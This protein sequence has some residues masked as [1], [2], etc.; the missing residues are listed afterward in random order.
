MANIATYLARIKNAILG[1]EVRDSIH[2]SIAAIN[3]D[4]GTANTN[5]SNA[6]STA[7]SASTAASQAVSTA[8]AASE[9]SSQAV[10][11]ANAAKAESSTASS[12]AQTALDNSQAAKDAAAAANT[13]AGKANEATTAANAAAANANTKATA[14]ET[15]TSA[16]NTAA[17]TANKAA[18]NLTTIISEA[19]SATEAA[20]AAAETAESKATE[21]TTAATQATAAA[22]KAT[23][24]TTAATQATEAATKATGEANTATE[25]ANEAADAA[26]EAAANAKPTI[27][28]SFSDF[29]RP[30][31]A[32][33][34]YVDSSSD[35]RL[36]YTWDEETSEYVLTG[37]AGGDLPSDAV[38]VNVPAE[39]WALE[40]TSQRYQKTV[41]VEGML[42]GTGG[43]WDIVRAGGVI[44]KEES[45]LSLNITDVERLNNS[46]KIS[47][48]SQPSKQFQ[49][50]LY[51]TYKEAAEGDVLISDMPEWFERVGTNESSIT[52]LG[53]RISEAESG[54][55]QLNTSLDEN[56]FK[57]Y[58]GLI[59]N[60]GNSVAR[61]YAG[62]VMSVDFNNLKT[63]G[64]AGLFA[65]DVNGPG[66]M[67]YVINLCLAYNNAVTNLTQL[68]FGY[69][70]EG[71][72]F[73]MRGLYNGTWTAWK[74]VT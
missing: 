61:C 22:T 23:E 56:V 25:S 55:E 57:P 65:N 7:N 21:A 63:P 30:G 17:N 51:G 62:A 70:V 3:Q 31:N 54:I 14:A 19:E 26:N 60:I 5:A 69:G 32:N 35:P 59:P 8:N 44:S 28:G 4:V 33:Q 39:G 9:A 64:F 53:T 74:S 36:I 73:S 11:T 43:H 1:E 45:E 40:S 10:E 2:D 66:Y 27:F 72:K 15:A 58:S 18:E 24:A 46:I 71:N 13:A 16:A 52:S 34:L 12:N 37:G 67:C 49:L 38:I 47:C 50:I 68:A 42:A 41:T 20:N 48:I 29:P 6:V